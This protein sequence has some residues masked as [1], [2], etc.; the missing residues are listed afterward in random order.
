M[1]RRERVVAAECV[2]LAQY[3]EMAVAGLI[4]G[5]PADHDVLERYEWFRVQDPL[6]GAEQTI[7]AQKAEFAVM[8]GLKTYGELKWHARVSIKVGDGASGGNPF[9]T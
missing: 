3:R 2:Y 4:G 6:V 1:P 9:A 5:V 8:A 7:D